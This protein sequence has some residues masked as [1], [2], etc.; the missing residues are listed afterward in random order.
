MSATISFWSRRNGPP[1]FQCAEILT[2]FVQWHV[3]EVQFEEIHGIS[4]TLNLVVDKLVTTREIYRAD[5]LARREAE[6]DD[7]FLVNLLVGLL[8][9]Y[10]GMAS[11]RREYYQE[12]VEEEPE[13]EVDLTEEEIVDTKALDLVSTIKLLREILT[14]VKNLASRD[15]DRDY[16]ESCIEVT[17]IADSV[18]EACTIYL[19]LVHRVLVSS[20]RRPRNGVGVDEG[21]LDALVLRLNAK[22]ASDKDKYY[23]Q[24]CA[25]FL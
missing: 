3:S 7:G 2:N 23:N 12:V 10:E 14:I 6:P 21:E 22:L 15:S 8:N 25:F 20:R 17:K 11:R 18:R 9:T 16:V 5:R 19:D 4:R 24:I 13:L 1:G